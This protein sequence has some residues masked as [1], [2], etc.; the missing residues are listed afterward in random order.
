ME[1]MQ[2]GVLSKRAADCSWLHEP[3]IALTEP[4]D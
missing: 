1:I 2:S 3:M 4:Y